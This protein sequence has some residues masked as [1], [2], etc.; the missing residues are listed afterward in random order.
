[1]SCVH[2]W[3]LNC[4]PPWKLKQHLPV[5]TSTCFDL[6]IEEDAQ[7][8]TG[9]WSWN[10][11]EYGRAFRRDQKLVMTFLEKAAVLE[12]NTCW[13]R[14]EPS[15]F[16]T[17]IVLKAGRSGVWN[18]KMRIHLLMY[19]ILPALLDPRVYSACNRNEYQKQKN[20]VWAVRRADNN[21]WA[22]LDNVG[23]LISHNR[24]GLHDLYG[25]S[26]TF[27]FKTWRSKANHSIAIYVESQFLGRSLAA[28]DSAVHHSYHF[29]RCFVVIADMVIYVQ[30]QTSC[31]L[32]SSTRC[33][34]G[35]HLRCLAALVVH[36]TEIVI[37]EEACVAPETWS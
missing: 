25:D 18:P 5:K 37:S 6:L 29:T 12:G 23:S 11:E 2:Y 36:C 14:F 34:L 26:F 17:G 13:S 28:I 22:D 7:F 4:S 32:Q 30:N 33:E 1:M 9:N 3:S 15:T 19:L 16:R 24:V 8:K 31:L 35:F 20:C 10:E 27:T 21:L